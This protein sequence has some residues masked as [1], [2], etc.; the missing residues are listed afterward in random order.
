MI[1]KFF[2]SL[3]LIML[4]LAVH[5]YE[6]IMIQ[7]ISD[8]KRT[9]IT[10]N[11]K[12]Q[13]IIPGVTGTFTAEDISVLAKAITVTGNFTQWELVNK[14]ALLPF[15]KGSIVTYY[16]ATEY[17]WALAPEKERR[18]Y[19]KSQ[20]PTLKKSWVFKGGFSRGLS[21][22]VSDTPASANERGGFMAEVY[23]EQDFYY[24]FAWD[25]GLRY[26]REMI[27]YTNASYQTNRSVLIAD[28]IYYFDAFQDYISGN[29]FTSLGVG[30]GLSE[31]TTVTLR[32]TGYVGL[33]PAFKLGLAL[34]LNEDWEFITDGAFESLQTQETQEDGR[35]QT[36]TQTNFK[37]GFGLR[38]FL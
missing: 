29:L 14:D 25:I 20:V 26:E 27:N 10:R 19:I 33:L 23:R 9:F 32:Q 5:A 38:K 18:K 4:P 28:I 31:T 16:P 8:T 11:G 3:F 37:V 7:G 6:L 13:G 1:K 12:R 34:P 17:I 2:L 24:N 21:D 30:Y 35:V 15:E 36:T 22:T